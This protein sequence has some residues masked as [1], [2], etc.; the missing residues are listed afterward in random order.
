MYQIV[1]LLLVIHNFLIGFIFR[2][3]R[4]NSYCNL[5]FAGDL[6]TEKYFKINLM[7]RN[8]NISDFVQGQICAP[9]NEGYSQIELTRRPKI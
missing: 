6:F 8:A 5:Y 4:T 1:L 9:K 7:G 3:F 2:G